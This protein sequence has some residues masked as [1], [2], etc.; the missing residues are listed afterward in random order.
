MTGSDKHSS[1]FVQRINND[2]KNYG[3]VSTLIEI[4]AT[5]STDCQQ[6]WF[7]KDWKMFLFFEKRPV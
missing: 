3:I 6:F 1:L 5:A 7:G 4:I 2:E